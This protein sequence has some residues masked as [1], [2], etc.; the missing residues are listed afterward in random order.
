MDAIPRLRISHL[1]G[2]LE[3]SMAYWRDNPQRVVAS[4]QRLEGALTTGAT[5]YGVNTGFGALARERVAETQLE[6][7]QRN[8]LLSH[9]VGVGEPLKPE[10]CRL[11]LRL[12][13]HALGL[14]YSGV[15]LPTFQ[16]LLEFDARD[17]I[18]VV[19]SRGSVGASGDLAPL[20]HLC[21]PLIGQ[22]TFW[23]ATGTGQLPAAVVLA[24][25]GWEPLALAPKDGL[26]LING[27]QFM[28]AC[29]AYVLEKAHTLTALF[30]L[31]A[32][33]SLEAL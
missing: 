28:S 20:A 7:L 23:D 13:I 12:K 17:R 24:Q 1:Y 25:E 26:A 30:D 5:I 3:A 19:P 21:L 22:G 18:P 29:G 9:A 27:T 31:A 4:R 6:Q 14:G 16:R 10:I 33:M 8:L 11:M 2:D 15:S 32:A